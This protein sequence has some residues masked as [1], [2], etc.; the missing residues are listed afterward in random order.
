MKHSLNT[1]LRIFGLLL[2][3]TT[4]ISLFACGGENGSAETST[5]DTDGITDAA[6]NAVTTEQPT[7]D[8]GTTEEEIMELAYTVTDN[9]GENGID[10][11]LDFE[12]G[13]DLRILQIADP[14]IQWLDGAR[15]ERYEPIRATFFADGITDHETRVW[16]HMDQAVEVTK[17]DLIVLTG[18][19]IYGEMDDS[20]TVWDELCTKM[21]S[22]EIPWLS[23]FGNHDNESAKGV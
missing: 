19:N 11:T 21:D 7:T 2:A 15:P 13:R 14:Q 16:R 8:D 18:D 1:R 23:V 12:A 3:L 22:Y 4:G 20:G 10:F 5:S 9:N 6:T 17:P